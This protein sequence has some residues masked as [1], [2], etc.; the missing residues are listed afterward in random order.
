MMLIYL[1]NA[2][3]LIAEFRE[4]IGRA[5]SEI[6]SLLNAGYWGV[7]MAGADALSKLSE[8]GKEGI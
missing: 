7:R 8:R 6:I 1:N 4:S 2:D 5:I 3:V